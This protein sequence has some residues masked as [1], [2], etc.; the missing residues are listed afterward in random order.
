[1]QD[2]KNTHGEVRYV[3]LE[4]LGKPIWDVQ[5]TREQWIQAVSA[6]NSAS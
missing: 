5:I 4:E 6:L 1:L 2:K 3:L